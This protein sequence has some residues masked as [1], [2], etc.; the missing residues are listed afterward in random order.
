[1]QNT[2]IEKKIQEEIRRRAF[3]RADLLKQKKDSHLDTRFTIDA[4]QEVTGLPR[5]ELEQIADDVRSSF[6]SQRKDYFSIKSQF[7]LVFGLL[8]ALAL[9]VYGLIRWLF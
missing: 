9:L 2:N 6:K 7:S 1:M 3:A 8:A 5:S 4:L